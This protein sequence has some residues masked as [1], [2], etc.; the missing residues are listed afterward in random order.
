MEKG[1]VRRD[2]TQNSKEKVVRLLGSEPQG[3]R[4][5]EVVQKRSD[6][7]LRSR[8]IVSHGRQE[9]MTSKVT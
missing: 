6:L 5:R 3:R 8:E 7:Q 4:H 2:G 9:K 1:K